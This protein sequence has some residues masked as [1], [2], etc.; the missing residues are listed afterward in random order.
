MSKNHITRRREDTAEHTLTGHALVDE[1]EAC[2]I[3]GGSKPI[4]KYTLYRGIA[5]G[6]F[7]PGIYVSPNTVRYLRSELEAVVKA[8]ISARSQPPGLDVD[9]VASK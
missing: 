8:A 3:I 9:K 7:P 6:R 4:S 1:V 2:R 5:A